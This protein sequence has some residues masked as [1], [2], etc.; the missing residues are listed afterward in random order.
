MQSRA[1][2]FLSGLGLVAFGAFAVAEPPTVADICHPGYAREH[3]MSEDQSRSIKRSMLPSGHRLSEYELDHII[4]LCLGGSND[5][6]NL[7]MQ[8]IDEAHE[9]DK[10]EW[11]ACRMV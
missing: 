11:K 2:S 4:P 6:S 10:L 8:P 9:K 5:R 7:Q 1:I 3:R